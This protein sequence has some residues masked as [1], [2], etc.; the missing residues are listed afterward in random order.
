MIALMGSVACQKQIPREE[1]KY[2]QRDLA[3]PSSSEPEIFKFFLHGTLTLCNFQ[4]FNFR[5]IK[6]LGRDSKN[7][8]K[9]WMGLA[10]RGGP[11]ACEQYGASTIAGDVYHYSDPL[12]SVQ[13]I[14][15]Q[16]ITHSLAGPEAAVLFLKKVLQSSATGFLQRRRFNSSFATNSSCIFLLV[17]P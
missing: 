14:K 5:D 7:S 2:S 11:A 8:N 16:T 12:N 9:V 10:R 1:Q 17:H 3:C 13:G 4:L 15:A 6:K